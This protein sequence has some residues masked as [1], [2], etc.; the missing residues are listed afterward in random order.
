MTTNDNGGVGLASY[1][2]VGQV[3]LRGFTATGN[4]FGGLNSQGTK[5]MLVRSTVTGNGYPPFPG[6][7]TT[8]DIVSSVLPKLVVTTCDHS[9]GPNGTWG[10]CSAD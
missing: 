9:W 10:V 1:G 2:D 3:R 5:T 6:L 7:P 8:L 4:G